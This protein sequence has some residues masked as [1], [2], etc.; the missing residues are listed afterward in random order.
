M[1][2]RRAYNC[3]YYFDAVRDIIT[4]NNEMGWKVKSMKKCIYLVTLLC[5]FL[6]W[7]LP[8]AH[9][10]EMRDGIA[11]VVN[12]DVITRT[13]LEN[14][15]GPVIE[16]INNDARIEDKDNL[17]SNARHMVLNQL[18]DRL[19]L[20]QEAT[21]LSIDVTD[22]DVENTIRAILTEKNVSY[23]NLT[24]YFAE[25]NVTL[26]QYKKEMRDQLL[27]REIIIR[28]IRNKV[29]ISDEE[30]GA[31]YAE[32]KDEYEGKERV[33]LQQ[34]LIV[35]P[36]DGSVEE[37]RVQRLKAARLHQMLRQGESFLVLAEKY[38]E[39]PAA[40][41]GGDLGFVEKG[42]MHT[43]VDNVAFKLGIG[44]IS[45]VVESP[46]GFHIIR[47]VDKRGAGLMTLD[48]VRDD[49]VRAIIEQKV[50]KKFAAWLENVR[51]KS[52][53]DIRI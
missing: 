46:I 5:F 17:L 1:D 21:R 36:R 34:I 48:E 14:A 12:G 42:A 33:R 52:L 45:P 11:A 16:R 8:C 10:G 2:I 43:S 30:I 3:R 50:Q 47:V 4:V 35:K 51:E 19:C 15:L 25:R 27:K 28:E 9:A 18:I 20:Y 49:I 23:D 22:E 32:H 38:S 26:E 7:S 6:A 24:E 31:Y 53:I 29:T 41:S 37:G 39:G 13:E 40:A 44:D